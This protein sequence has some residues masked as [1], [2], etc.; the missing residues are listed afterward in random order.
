MQLLQYIDLTSFWSLWY[1]V[2]MI[3]TWSMTS[4]W[5]IGVPFD[6]VVRADRQGG[7]FA[8]HLDTLVEINVHRLLYYFERGGVF[9]AAFVGFVLAGL[10]TLGI[11]FGNEVALA[12]FM[13]LAPL[14][15]VMAFSVRFAYRVRQEGWR[16]SELRTHMRWRR[17]WNQVIGILAI[18]AASAVAVW[19]N[20]VMLGYLP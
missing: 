8:E 1:W 17:F 20:L 18:S 10:G 11:Y 16:G 12:F 15:L 13:L 5:T 9:F 2:L 19:I 4:H 3:I 14:S 7:V 6:A